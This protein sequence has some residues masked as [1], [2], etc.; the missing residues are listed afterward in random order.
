M[1]IKLFFAIFFGSLSMAFGQSTYQL[2][3]E[4][5][6]QTI[7]MAA[8]M[9]QEQT[10]GVAMVV[11]LDGEPIFREEWGLRD[12]EKA[13]PVTDNTVF[14]VGSMSQ[15][16]A[17]FAIFRLVKEG[18]LDL[19]TD[20]NNYLQSWQL[21]ENKITRSR[22]VTI[23]DLCL[24]RRGFKFPYKPDGFTK[25]ALLPTHL[26]LLEGERP[27]QNPP[28][29]LKKDVNR[30]GNESFSTALILQ[31]ILMDYYQQFFPEIAQQQVFEP[32]GMK[33]SFFAAE[34]TV[35]QQR[36]MAVGYDDDNQRL[37]GD[38]MRYP[39]LAASGMY[40]TA[41]DYALF[42]QAALAALEGEDER[43]LTQSLAKELLNPENSE[44]AMLFNR[45]GTNFFWGGATKG[46][47]SQFEAD[48]LQ[49]RWVVVVLMNDNVNWRFNGELRG[50][51]IE[52]AMQQI[53]NPTMNPS[54]SD[55]HE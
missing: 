11:L 42:V 36:D 53:A 2:Q 25:G 21:P 31:Q 49:H 10:N 47:Y 7:G 46:F 5:D 16:V 52:L 1:K 18:K 14:Q 17:Q 3:F 28:V 55:N 19:D 9:A 32:L 6:G 50:K 44:E 30:S 22:P 35:D 41:Y 4:Q 43:F 39:E 26:Q 29:R 33:N 37:A 48:A 8:R 27:A 54:K 15:P 40:T 20:I 51:G 24:Q 12:A 38:F 23:R 13:L 45:G 34:P